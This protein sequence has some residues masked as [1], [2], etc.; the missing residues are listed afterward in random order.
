[1][2]WRGRQE[3]IFLDY[4]SRVSCI[5]WFQKNLFCNSY[6][7]YLLSYQMS[8]SANYFLCCPVS[9]QRNR[10]C[11]WNRRYLLSYQMSQS[12]MLFVRH[13]H[14]KNRTN[15]PL[16]GRLQLTHDEKSCSFLSYLSR[17]YDTEIILARTI[18]NGQDGMGASAIAKEMGIGRAS[19]YRALG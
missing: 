1:V 15:K 7:C 3:S 16:L 9:F 6:R 18:W 17:G 12:D 14:S 11:R 2:R 8:Q 10:F 5:S 4:V 13:F 19:V